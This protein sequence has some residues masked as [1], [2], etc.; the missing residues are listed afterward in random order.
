MN[1]SGWSVQYLGA[2]GTGNW[3]ATNLSGTIQP[4]QYYLVQENSSGIAGSPLPAPD[5]TGTIAMAS[6]AGKVALVSSTTQLAGSCPTGGSIFDL[7]GY[8]SSASCFEGIGPAPAPSATTADFRKLG[9][10]LTPT[11][12]RPTSL[13]TPLV[14]AIPFRQSI[15][16]L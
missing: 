4:G 15:T 8:G 13:F 2:T 16:A 3:S 7:V 14:H 11:T 1:L 6:T 12:M 9:V 5:A 10:A